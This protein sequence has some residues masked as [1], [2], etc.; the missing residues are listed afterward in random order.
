MGMP[1]AFPGSCSGTAPV[2]IQVKKEKKK[3]SEPGED[4]VLEPS[5]VKESFFSQWLQEKCC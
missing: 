3:G 4:E 2:W 1:S 5:L